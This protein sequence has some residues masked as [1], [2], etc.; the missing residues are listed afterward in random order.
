MWYAESR[1]RSPTSSFARRSL[2]VRWRGHHGVAPSV[3]S[4]LVCPLC[5]N[6][7]S[8]APMNVRETKFTP[9]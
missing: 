7:T 1:K 5:Y 9:K 6:T 8:C 4:T 3:A 2:G